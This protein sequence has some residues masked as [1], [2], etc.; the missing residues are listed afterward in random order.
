MSRSPLQADGMHV[1]S[2]SLFRCRA[3]NTWLGQLIMPDLDLL[4]GGDVIGDL[5]TGRLEGAVTQPCA[6]R[7][8]LVAPLDETAAKRSLGLA[9][10]Q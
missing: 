9:P 8:G 10:S 7:D 4:V 1:R 2:T 6:P 5:A 3:A